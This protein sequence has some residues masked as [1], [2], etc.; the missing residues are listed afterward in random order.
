MGKYSETRYANMIPTFEL[1]PLPAS[2]ASGPEKSNIRVYEAGKG[3][4]SNVGIIF[5]YRVSEYLPIIYPCNSAVGGVK[6]AVYLARPR[7]NLK[8]CILPNV[9]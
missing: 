8:S 4:S 6:F 7:V 1:A 2:E 9:R 5:A 3:A